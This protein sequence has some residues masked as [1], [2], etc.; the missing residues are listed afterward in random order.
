MLEE[1]K[2]NLLFIYFKVIFPKLL[3]LSVVIRKDVAAVKYF[4][5]KYHALQR[6]GRKYQSIQLHLVWNTELGVSVQGE[7]KVD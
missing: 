2:N 5:S 7:I 4:S 1:K 6:I 3:L